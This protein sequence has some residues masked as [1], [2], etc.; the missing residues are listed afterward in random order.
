MGD[1]FGGGVILVE[2]LSQQRLPARSLAA[3]LR[4]AGIPARLVG[5]AGAADTEAVVDEVCASGA[6]LVVISQLFAHLLTEHLGLARTLRRQGVGGHIT[7]VGPLATFAWVDLLE[8][9]PALDSVL[10]GEAEAG[11]VSLVS[12]ASQG[13]GWQQVPGLAWRTPDLCKN[14]PDAG[15][16]SLDDLPPPFYDG[17]LPGGDGSRFVT[18]EASRGCYHQCAFCLPGAAQRQTGQAYRMRSAGSSATN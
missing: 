15:G 11:I 10:C 16:L 12:A 8:A 1:S 13:A 6:T 17:P 18:I 3:V 7:M 2:D 9:C 4:Q 5:F 14:P